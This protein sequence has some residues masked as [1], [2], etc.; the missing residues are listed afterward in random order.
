MSEI[1]Q[2][3]N[4]D[5]AIWAAVCHGV[6]LIAT[7]ALAF[8]LVPIVIMLAKRN[9][10]FIVQHAKEQL[11]FQLS[12]IFWGVI[13]FLTTV[14]AGATAAAGGS[15]G[16]A[17]LATGAFVLLCVQGLFVFVMEI[18]ATVKAAGGNAYR[19]PLTLRLI[20]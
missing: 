14:I 16:L 15:A 17:T 12:M 4:D 7:A 9:S 18:V 5:D 3:Q 8:W 19:F 6:S 1:N 20:K 10:P 2:P 13:L 11:N